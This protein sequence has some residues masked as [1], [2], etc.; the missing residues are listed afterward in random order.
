MKKIYHFLKNIS[1]VYFILSLI[2]IFLTMLIWR[3]LGINVSFF[4]MS[5]SL[6]I[7]SFFITIA[8]EFFMLDK[9]PSYLRIALGYIVLF[10][11]TFV[12]RNIF[13]PRLFRTSFMLL[14]FILICTI[15][16]FMFLFILVT[17]NKKEEKEMNRALNDINDDVK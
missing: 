2:M 13:G 3:R 17:I 7:I 9:V 8:I 14:I 1:I 15:I 16:Y 12:I 5:R 6:F 4:R 11:T 10:F